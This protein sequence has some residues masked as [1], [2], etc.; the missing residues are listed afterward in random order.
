MKKLVLTMLIGVGTTLMLHGCKSATACDDS[1]AQKI[2][3]EIVEE[4]PRPAPQ[5]EGSDTLAATYKLINIRTE[6][7]DDKLEKSECAAKVSGTDGAEYDITYTI[8]NTTDNKMYVEVS[9]L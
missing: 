1:D 9:G 3:L 4:N 5:V 8:S 2:V 7:M 6:S